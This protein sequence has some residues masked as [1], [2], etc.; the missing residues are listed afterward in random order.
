[1]SKEASIGLTQIKAKSLPYYGKPLDVN[2]FRI[3]GSHP[4]MEQFFIEPEIECFLT[5]R[6]Q[7]FRQLEL[8]GNYSS[9]GDVS[10]F[11]VISACSIASSRLLQKV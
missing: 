9:V 8:D 2:E 7:H 5:G 4:E 6:G 1:M 3:T 10:R 11:L